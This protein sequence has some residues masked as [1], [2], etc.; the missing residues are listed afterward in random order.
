MR[1]I[2]PRRLVFSG[3][4]VRVIAYL[5]ALHV[6]EEKTL[7]TNIRE[8]CGVSAGSLVALMMALGYS[9]RVIQRFCYEYDFTS[10]RALEP[11][12]VLQFT[13]TFGIDDGKSLEQLIHKFLKHKGFPPTTTFQELHNSGKAKDLRVWASNLQMA[14]QEEFSVKTTPDVHIAFAI[15]ASMA[16]PLYYIPVH[17]PKTKTL[18]ADG[19][20]YDNYPIL[21]LSE[22][23]RQ[24]AL[25]FTFE[26]SQYPVEIK[27]LSDF[28]S[29][30]F[31]GY[32]MPAYQTLI[33]TYKSRT[34]IIPCSEFPALHFDA[35]KEEKD[36]LVA[37]GRKAT[38][39]FLKK[40]FLKPTTRRYSI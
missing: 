13:E 40:S 1:I 11:E 25:G 33:Q 14:R 16:F 35:T 30:I 27:S 2:P 28:M 24:E 4:G 7:L 20:I 29:A 8:Y 32:Y 22:E 3:G 38:E 36:A 39:A 19:G 12:S 9:L 6:L 23:E 21:G 26:W 15:R 18:L 34:I 37:C 5:G 31:S 17:H 10:L